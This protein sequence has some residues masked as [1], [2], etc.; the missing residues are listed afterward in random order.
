MYASQYYDN[1]T[2]EELADIALKQA[3]IFVEQYKKRIMQ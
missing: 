3:D 2:M 1:K